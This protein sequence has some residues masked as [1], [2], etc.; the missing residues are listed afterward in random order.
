MKGVKTNGLPLGPDGFKAVRNANL[1]SL[2]RDI[3]EIEAK[4][5]RRV[6]AR[7][8]MMMMKNNTLTCLFFGVQHEFIHCF[9]IC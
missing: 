1:L 8:I 3:Q 5:E 7:K 9:V 4:K 6:Y 2:L